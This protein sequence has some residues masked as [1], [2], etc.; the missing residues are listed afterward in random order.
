MSHTQPQKIRAFNRKGWMQYTRLYQYTSP[1][2]TLCI[3]LR[4]EYFYSERG[5]LRQWHSLGRGPNR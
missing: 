4:K 2:N 1:S 5:K 3:I